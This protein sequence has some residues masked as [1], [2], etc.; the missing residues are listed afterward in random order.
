MVIRDESAWSLIKKEENH[1]NIH[2]IAFPTV[3]TKIDALFL[4]ILL[5]KEELSWSE[6]NFHLWVMV[7]GLL[8]RL[9]SNYQTTV[10]I[11][12]SYLIIEE[13]KLIGILI[14]LTLYQRN[15]LMVCL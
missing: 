8:H 7:V 14:I 12:F 11:V 15:I 9:R 6:E 3:W 1:L 5:K 4:N 10:A 13:G 2:F